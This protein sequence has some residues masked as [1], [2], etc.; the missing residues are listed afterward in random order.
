MRLGEPPS[1]CFFLRFD[2]PLQSVGRH[3]DRLLIYGKDTL[4]VERTRRIGADDPYFRK[5][6]LEWSKAL[7]AAFAIS[8]SSIFSSHLR[9][10]LNY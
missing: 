8:T 4:K 10:L 6:S 9:I 5:L 3:A 1:S 2:P 7:R